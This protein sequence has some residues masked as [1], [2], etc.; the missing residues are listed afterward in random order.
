MACT[1]RCKRAPVVCG[2]LASFASGPSRSYPQHYLAM[3]TGP[4]GDIHPV[5]V[6]VGRAGNGGQRPTVALEAVATRL[7]H[8]CNMRR[9]GNANTPSSCTELAA[10]GAETPTCAKG[11]SKH[12][13]SST[14]N[15]RGEL[16]IHWRLQ[17][18]LRF[19][20]LRSKNPY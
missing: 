13:G 9:R 4:G 16:Q 12:H 19:F 8:A 17:V 14:P 10:N 15:D 20:P 2:P 3:C 11:V 5:L 1:V 7:A 6:I 18:F